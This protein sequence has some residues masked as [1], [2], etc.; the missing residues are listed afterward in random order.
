V[1]T[2]EFEAAQG[3]RTG[4]GGWRPGGII[5][6]NEIGGVE[7]SGAKEMPMPLFYFD[8]RDGERFTRDSQG[9]NFNGIEGARDEAT[10]VLAEVARDVVPAADRRRIAIEVRDEAKKP[11]LVVAL[12]FEAAGPGTKRS[13]DPAGGRSLPRNER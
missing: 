3:A 13:P 11:L 9:V 8:V 10:R 1:R 6:Q 2:V 4:I 12:M 7:F 5:E